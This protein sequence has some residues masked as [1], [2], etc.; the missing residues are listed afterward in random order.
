MGYDPAIIWKGGPRDPEF[1][2]LTL[3]PWRIELASMSLETG[4]VSKV[5]RA[6]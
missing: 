1:G 4:T 6:P 5:W 2:V 3:K